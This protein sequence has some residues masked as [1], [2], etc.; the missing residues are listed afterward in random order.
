[1]ITSITTKSAAAALVTK[2]LTTGW[3]LNDAGARWDAR[4]D[5]LPLWTPAALWRLC[6]RVRAAGEALA[7][8][9]SRVAPPL[10]VDM[11]TD[12]LEPMLDRARCA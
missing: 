11:D 5:T 6:A 3:A 8:F 12:V 2:A 10:G 7:S 4:L 9:A 1:M